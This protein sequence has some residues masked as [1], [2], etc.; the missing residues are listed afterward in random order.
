MADPSFRIPP[1]GLRFGTP[2]TPTNGA[3]VPDAYATLA[4]YYS[5][6]IFMVAPGKPIL[7]ALLRIGKR[8][9]AIP[10]GRAAR[11][12]YGRNFWP[13]WSPIVNPAPPPP[14][15]PPL[16]A[17]VEPPPAPAPEPAPARRRGGR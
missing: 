15:A 14:P 9:I 7:G 17:R 16:L 5:A 10:N 12:S 2:Q 3:S 13:Q 11:T 6:Q 8:P 4:S 1:T